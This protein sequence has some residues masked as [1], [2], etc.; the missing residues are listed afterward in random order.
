MF[1]VALPIEVSMSSTSLGD[2]NYGVNSEDKRSFWFMCYVLAALHTDVMGL[3]RPHSFV[4][5]VWVLA[6]QHFLVPCMER[7]GRSGAR[8]RTPAGP[9]GIL[10]FF[11][12]HVEMF[13]SVILVFHRV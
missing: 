5:A 4:L 1:P 13:H 12:Y 8:K 6:M 7:D 11:S 2:D 3:T 9:A 10:A